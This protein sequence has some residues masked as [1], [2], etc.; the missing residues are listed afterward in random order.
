MS[1]N[2]KS[3]SVAGFL[4]LATWLVLAQQKSAIAVPGPDTVIV[5][6]SSSQPVPVRQQGPVSVTGDVS[7]N[8]LP[9]VQQ[10]AGSV[11][12]SNLPAVQQI[13]GTVTVARPAVRFGHGSISFESGFPRSVEF[14]PDVVVTDVVLDRA[15]FSDDAEICDV[16]LYANEGGVFGPVVR[17]RPSATQR[18]VE[19]HLE[20]G[21]G[22]EAGTTRGLFLNSDCRVQFFWTGHTVD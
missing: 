21:Y 13:A 8:N 11:A 12:I 17:L 22:S 16:W 18:T 15:N 14:P 19:L 7:V 9:A 5:A 4:M 6:N 10:V 1:G 20:T 2:N 3:L